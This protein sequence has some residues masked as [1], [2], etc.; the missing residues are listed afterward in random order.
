LFFKCVSLD[1]VT[2]NCKLYCQTWGHKMHRQ[3]RLSHSVY[4]RVC[5]RKPITN[6]DGF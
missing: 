1:C 2:W 3:H 5:I 4:T 6:L